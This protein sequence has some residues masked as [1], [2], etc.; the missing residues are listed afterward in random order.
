MIG[1]YRCVPPG[2][3]PD[4]AF[5]PPGRRFCSI[6]ACKTVKDDVIRSQHK[7]VLTPPREGAALINRHKPRQDADRA[8]PSVLTTEAYT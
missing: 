7:T 4:S 2:F 6:S 3:T 8:S 5:P 1:T